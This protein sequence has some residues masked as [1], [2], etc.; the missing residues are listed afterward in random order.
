MRIVVAH[1]YYQQAGGEDGVFRAEVAML[2]EAG[3]QVETFEV[4]NDALAAQGKVA[5]AKSTFWN[6]DSHRQIAALVEHHSADVV[7]FHNTLPLISPAGYYAARKAGAAV[8]QTL[9]NY[10]LGCV[11]ALL[12]REGR[13]CEECLGKDFAWP[14]VVHACYRGSRAA[15]LVVASMLWRHR[16][17]GTWNKAVDRYI[18]LTEFAKEKINRTG[19]PLEK[20][21][22]K[23]NFIA[24]DP[25]PGSHE[26]GFA[27]F[28]GRLSEEKG[29]T[30]L[31]AAWEQIGETCELRLVG[32]GPLGDAVR[33]AADRNPRIVWLGKQPQEV[34]RAQMKSAGFLV[35]PS[36]W[37]EGFPLVIV[38]AFACGLPVVASDLGAMSTIIR[39]GENGMKFPPGNVEALAE[40][41]RSTSN[42]PVRL[43]AL[44]EQA[45]TDFEA[46]Y[47]K[48]QNLKTLL[49]IYD[50]AI[51]ARRATP[52][53][54]RDRG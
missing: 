34:V 44:Q 45:R 23:P 4:H 37:Y 21:A 48:A 40:A 51:A 33:E 12:F 38:E 17:L 2:R 29:V 53:A 19:V 35:L 10:R 18:A 46:N 41:V 15:S 11:N 26:G 7:H 28:V 54:L 30:K 47:T 36:L 50:E 52:P 32:D 6:E 14:G 24:P 43:S 22:V 20:I 25:G 3:H 42:D 39:H 16:K 49:S 1:N 5:A 13:V 27:L 8:V 31:L 9:H